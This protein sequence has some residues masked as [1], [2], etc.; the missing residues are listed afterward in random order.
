VLAVERLGL[1]ADDWA[2]VV[3]VRC[4]ALRTL[5]PAAPLLRP[6]ALGPW[7]G[8]RREPAPSEVL[9][10]MLALALRNQGAASR[11]GMGRFRFRR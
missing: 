10:L 4:L 11:D 5:L 2:V 7:R 1:A 3:A 8:F 9:S 6:V